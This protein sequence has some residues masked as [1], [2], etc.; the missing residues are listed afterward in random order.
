M[1]RVLAIGWE[2]PARAPGL[3]MEAANYRTWQ[4]VESLRLDGHEVCLVAGR[5]G[6]EFPVGPLDTV[7]EHRLTYVPMRFSEPFWARG[8]QRTHDEFRPDCTLGI[9]FAGALRATRLRTEQPRWF[10]IYGDHTAEMQAAAHLRESERGIA[11]ELHFFRQLLKV[12]DA[13]SVCS[14]AQ[15]HAL[16][17]QLSMVGRLNAATFGYELVHVIQPGAAA[18]DEAPPPGAL[19]GPVVDPRAKVI[20]WVGG[21]NNWTDV[22]TLHRG[23]TLAMAAEPSLHFVAVGGQLPG[24]DAYTRFAGLVAASPFRD[25][26]HLLGWQPVAAVPSYYVDADLAITLDAAC[27][28]AE[29]GTRTRLLE[30]MQHGLPIVTTLACELSQIIE[31]EGLGL[32]FA[33]GDWRAMG[34]HILALTTDDARRRTMGERAR[35]CAATTLCFANA[36]APLRRWVCTPRLAPDRCRDRSSR[37][38]SLEHSTRAMV[39]QMIWAVAGLDK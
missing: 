23:L 35:A 28:E 24:C 27:Y 19:R 6:A 33:I 16:I 18:I 34:Q 25:R 38:Y 3:R 17:G 14:G 32:T 26:F 2:L 30:M 12:G 9:T 13:F 11:T 29:L 1:S 37:V 5:I 22:D 36:S 21:F 39:R 20:L 8:L 10:D 31:T 7:V 4:L 15:R